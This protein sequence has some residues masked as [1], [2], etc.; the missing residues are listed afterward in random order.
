MKPTT[1]PPEVL[2]ELVS[3][4]LCWKL[5]KDF[6]PDGGISFNRV[7]NGSEL[8]YGSMWW[9]IGTNLLTATQAREMI[10]HMLGDA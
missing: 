9:P 1:L 5:P 10:L 3:R 4:F 8:E 2:N 7:V 6:C